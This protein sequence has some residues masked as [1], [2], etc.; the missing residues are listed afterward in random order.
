MR[1]LRT[2]LVLAGIAAAGTA[3]A[4]V[5]PSAQVAQARLLQGWRQPD[6][7]HLAAIAIDLAPGWHTYWRAPGEA[8]IPPRFDWS[9]SR[10][11]RS[12]AYEWPRP[13]RFSLYGVRTLGYAGALVLPVRMVPED[14]DAPIEA[15]L[16]LSYGVCRD[17]CIPAEASLAAQLPA[18]GPAQNRAPIEAALAE[19]ARSADEAGVTAVSCGLAPGDGGME[20][21]AE[22]TFRSP[23]GPDQL[24]VIETSDP[25]LW[26]APSESRTEGRTVTARASIEGSPQ[27]AVV[28]RDR[29]RLTVLDGR[30]VV[31]IP[32]CGT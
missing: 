21:T 31:D 19:R 17:I 11:L 6:G 23:P 28:A 9:G 1:L 14:P 24:A 20:L 3:A 22:V 15:E 29:I 10:N 7:S 27:G 16:A 25:G 18:Q 30:R 2:L 4:Q 26:I 12:V 13:E 32:G 5:Q 8:G